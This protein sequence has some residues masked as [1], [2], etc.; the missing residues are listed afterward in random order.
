MYHIVCLISNSY[1]LQLET[2]CVCVG[3]FVCVH[4]YNV[5]LSPLTLK[6]L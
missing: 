4:G 2:L 6:Y 3:V 5:V 1:Q